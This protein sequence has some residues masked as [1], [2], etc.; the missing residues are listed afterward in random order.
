MPLGDLF[1]IA[2]SFISL[3]LPPPF[4]TV[5]TPKKMID[6]GKDEAKPAITPD[7]LVPISKEKLEELK[8]VFEFVPYMDAKQ[9]NG[10]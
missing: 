8:K 7:Q 10:K 2:L 5:K 6:K 9:L 3:F 4:E 1:L